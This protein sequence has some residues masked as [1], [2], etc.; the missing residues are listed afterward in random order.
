MIRLVLFDIDGTLIR[1][2]GIGGRSFGATFRSVFAQE[3]KPEDVN[4]AG[5]TDL[6][7]LREFF[8]HYNITY[9]QEN[10]DLFTDTY[11]FWLEHLMHEFGGHVC[12]GVKE[13]IADL[14]ALPQEPIMGLLTGNLR[15]GAEIKLRHHG[16]WDHFEF[17]VFSDDHE[18]RNQLAAIAQQRAGQMI[19]RPLKGEE[20]LVI[21]DTPKDI[22]CA[23]HIGA[24]ILAVATGGHT[25]E[26]LRPHKPT[27]LVE[28][29]RGVRARDL[30][31]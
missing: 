19:G 11:V 9:S 29:L 24:K 5:R 27:W 22:D 25:M 1:T 7:L 30:N 28:N 3:H 12:T 10:L 2:R 17:G 26:D 23:R 15:I 31:A 21:G 16:L 18:D 4:F 8:K 20:V 14:K 6:S 13:L